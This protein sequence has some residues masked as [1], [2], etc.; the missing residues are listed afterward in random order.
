MNFEL[1][2]IIIMK[3][4]LCIMNYQSNHN[5]E[6]WIVNSELTEKSPMDKAK[7]NHTCLIGL[8]IYSSQRKFYYYI[9]PRIRSSKAERAALAPSPIAIVIC[10]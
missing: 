5:Y 7:K 1:K 4:E 3:F 8:N 9:T 6:F 10:L 2:L